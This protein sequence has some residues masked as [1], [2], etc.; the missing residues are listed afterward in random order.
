M[1]TVIHEAK[2]FILKLV[3][4]KVLGLAVGVSAMAWVLEMTDL[5]SQLESWRP[6]RLCVLDEM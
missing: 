5:S 2:K 6:A 3:C 1:L 4:L